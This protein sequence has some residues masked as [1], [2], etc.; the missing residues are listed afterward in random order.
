MGSCV[1]G[2]PKG[3]TRNVSHH[4]KKRSTSVDLN[5]FELSQFAQQ[6]PKKQ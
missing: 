4:T 2:N 1:N 5:Y 6:H 3:E